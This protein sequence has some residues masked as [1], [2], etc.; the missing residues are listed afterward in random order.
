MN[1]ITIS[2]AVVTRNRPDSLEQTLLSIQSQ[3]IAP[4]EVVVSDDSDDDMVANNIKIVEKFAY[5]YVKGPRKGL[6]A[7]RNNALRNCLGTH[8]RSM[9]DDHTFADDHFEKCFRKVKEDP[10]SIW[11]IGEV[12]FNQLG[13][14]DR[15]IGVPG[16][17]NI[18]GV[19]SAPADPQDCAAISCG[20]SIYPRSVVTNNILYCELFK[21]G[22]VHLEYG[23]RLRAQGYRIRFIEDS[24][25]I[26]HAGSVSSIQLRTADLEIVKHFLT[27]CY[28]I[29][30]NPSIRNYASMVL[31]I[32]RSFAQ[33]PSIFFKT[34][35]KAFAKFRTFKTSLPGIGKLT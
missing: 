5:K 35:S 22:N 2:V 11:I 29:V 9:D 21:F 12:H 31:I 23:L 30:Y 28:C 19:S 24:Y 25:I 4:Y 15:E 26:H 32:G 14:C 16:E 34:W 8:I 10:K 13:H 17:L 6:H 20:G 33:H 27:F 18:N 7:N 1:S 3:T